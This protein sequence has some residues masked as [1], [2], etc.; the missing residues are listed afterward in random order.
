MYRT[1]VAWFHRKVSSSSMELELRINGMIESLEVAPNESLLTLL[2]REGICSVKHGCETGECG[3]C[4]VLVEGVPRPGC[5]MLAAQAGG[6]TLTTVEGLS[7]PGKLHPL[8]AA[9]V[10]VGAVQCGFCTPGMLLSAYALLK[11]NPTPSESDVRDALSGNLCRCTGYARPVQAVLRAAAALRGEALP[12]LEHPTIDN[13]EERGAP[14]GKERVETNGKLLSVLSRSGASGGAV[15][16]TTKLPAVSAEMLEQGMKAPEQLQIVGQAVPALNAVKLATGKAVF[17]ADVQPQGMLYGRILTSPHAHAVIRSIDVAQA[18]AL[19]GVHAVLTYKDVPRIPYSSVEQ[20][21]ADGGLQDHY[22]LDTI[23]RYVGDRVAAV[24]A[25]TPEVAEQALGLIEV[26]YEVLPAILDVRQAADASAPCLHP[27]SESRGIYN[28]TRNIAA[29]VRA[30]VGDVERS[31]ASADMVVE[32]EYFI[33]PT[34]AAPLENHTVVTYF[35]ENDDL[36]VR[37]SNPLSHY[38]RHTLA[39]VLG[40]S[41]RRIHVVRPE[42]GGSFGTKGELLLEDL[43]SLL[44]IISQRPVTLEY[45]RAEEFQG[46]RVRP[47]HILRIKTGVMRDGR[48]VANQMVLL[49]DTGAH[50]THPLIFQGSV[51]TNALALYPCPNMRFAAEVLY[52][53]HT[54]AAAFLDNGPFQQ[55]FALESHIDEIA[56]RLAMDALELRR[57]NWI[58]TGDALPFARA[59]MKRDAG[60]M[61]ESCGL[62]ACLRVVEEKLN[63]AEKR[64]RRK[65]VTNG[66]YGHG[67]GIA[68]SMHSVSGELA[69]TSG[70]IIK[71]NED[72]VF[73]VFVSVN[74]ASAG[75]ATIIAQVAAEVL[76]VPLADIVIHSSDTANTP[77]ASGSGDAAAFYGGS[78]AV[79]KA[80]EQARRQL[81]NVAGRMLNAL[82]EALKINNGVVGSSDERQ[83]TIAQVAA[84]SLYVESRQIMTTASW[85]VQQTP[86]VCA[87][88]GVEVEVDTETGAVRVLNAVSAL[89]V[90]SAINPALLEGQ[91]LGDVTR[92][93]GAALAEELLYDQKGTLLTTSLRDYHIYSATDMPEV[94]TYLVETSDPYGPFG[95]KAV[96]AVP[97]YGIAPA[98]ANAVADAVGVRLRQL[99]LTPE[100]VLRALH[101]QA[102]TKK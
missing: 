55:F 98:V 48:I 101:A 90:G 10:E 8:Q 5:V 88:Q 3:A 65:R 61:V 82:P 59:G 93:L 66:R 100:R 95:A 14:A 94:Q 23:V 24:A 29:R 45:S 36:V 52:T 22:C 62:P 46:S 41:A 58:K 60:A 74:D 91:I 47:Q 86:L 50:G 68:L 43:C 38:V 49:A 34:Q 18:K 70:A 17:A 1:G 72:G 75:A 33:P 71:L 97:F 69:N 77:Y 9:F 2:R 44:T 16:V 63:W 30:E 83:V 92:G 54:P 78:S 4:T 81:L 64:E 35:D 85:K 13:K 53:N 84:H 39:H 32:N 7:S 20:G 57:K 19:P 40:L 79:K 56:Q 102:Q 42:I 21:S 6:C 26:E 12:P 67:V 76:G 87:A 99:P 25:E 15:G 28:A 27:E 96:A 31:F 80:A 37:T 51:S 73:D 89:D 11:R